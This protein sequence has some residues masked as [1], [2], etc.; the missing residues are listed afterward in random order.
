MIPAGPLRESL[1]SLKR[2][3]CVFINGSK[4]VIIEKKILKINEKIKIFYTS[5]KAQNINEFKDKNVV[6]F[7]GIGNPE[8][9]FNTL[10]DH[11]IN[12]VKEIRFPDHHKYSD[13]ELENLIQ[14]K[15]GNNAIL[16]TTEKDYFRIKENLKESIDYLKIKVEI[17]N[18]D[19]FI[20]ELK[21]II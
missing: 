2:A 15:K 19:K 21:K 4:N 12:V 13:K 10:K 5:T 18:Q 11:K 6:A 8:N 3:N 7:A 20:D 16:I 1:S 9:F 14:K 17:T